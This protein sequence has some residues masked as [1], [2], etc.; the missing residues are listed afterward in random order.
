MADFILDKEE[1]ESLIEHFRYPQIDNEKNRQSPG[2]TTQNHE[3][4]QIAA[5]F[6]FRK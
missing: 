2:K 5:A 4:F 3:L 1:K 6:F